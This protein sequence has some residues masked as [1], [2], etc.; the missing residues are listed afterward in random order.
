VRGEEIRRESGEREEG[1]DA[2]S[3]IRT[4]F[5]STNEKNV[6]GHFA[7]CH[8]N[9]VCKVTPLKKLYICPRCLK[10]KI[11]KMYE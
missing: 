5:L 10:S 2:T 7:D 3:S 1:D 4:S 9:T 6:C 11:K 8:E